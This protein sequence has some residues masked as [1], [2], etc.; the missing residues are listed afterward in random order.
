MGQY[1]LFVN[2]DKKQFVH[3]H[4]LGNGLKLLEFGCSGNGIMTA[5]AGLLSS[6]NGRGG[7]DIH[8]DPDT[9]LAAVVEEVIGSWAGDRIVIAGDYGDGGLYLEGVS[10]E[11]LQR[12]ANEVFTEGNR[13]AERVNLYAYARDMYED[14]SVEALA[15]ILQDGW[16]RSEFIEEVQDSVKRDRGRGHEPRYF[17][18]PSYVAYVWQIARYIPKFRSQI[19][20]VYAG[21]GKIADSDKEATVFARQKLKDLIARANLRQ[22]VSPESVPI[23]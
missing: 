20:K 10:Q 5:L 2:L 9:E 11:D 14:I 12:I 16:V 8:V 7:G 18:Y 3:P 21:F 17:G 15:V 4:A 23:A 22:S 19:R 1:Y 13:D 6:G